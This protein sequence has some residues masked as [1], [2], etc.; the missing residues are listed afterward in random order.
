MTSDPRYALI[1]HSTIN[2]GDEIQSIAVKQFLPRVDLLVDRDAP[3]RLPAGAS[4]RYK[5]VLNGWHTR[6]PENWP[7]APEFDALAVRSISAAR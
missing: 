5:I 2:L 7:P 1:S 3:N 6:R 4:G